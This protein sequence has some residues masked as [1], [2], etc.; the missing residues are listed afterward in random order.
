MDYKSATE[1]VNQS[2]LNSG[3]K[4]D[5]GKNYVKFCRHQSDLK[6]QADLRFQVLSPKPQNRSERSELA[7]FETCREI[8][9]KSNKFVAPAITHLAKLSAIAH[10]NLGNLHKDRN[11]W[12]DAIVQYRKAI[13]IDSKYQSAYLN[14]AQVLNEVEQTLEATLYFECAKKLDEQKAYW[15]LCLDQANNY[16]ANYDYQEAVGYYLQALRMQPTN[17]AIYFKLSQ[18]FYNLQQID[19]ALNY[20]KQA[21]DL[22]DQR[23]NEQRLM[24]SFSEYA[25]KIAQVCEQKKDFAMAI[26]FYLESLDSE[27]CRW[28]AYFNLGNI[29]ARLRQWNTSLKYYQQAMQIKPAN[30]WLL[31]NAGNVCLELGYFF[32]AREYYLEAIKLNK[33]GSAWTHYYLGEVFQ[34]LKIWTKSLAAYKAAQ[35]LNPHLKQINQKIIQVQKLVPSN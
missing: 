16:F 4:S 6:S 26:K 10:N 30:Y 34:N 18:C 25:Y 1:S 29:F 9:V 2:L 5:L 15:Q 28:Q 35:L 23:L 27:E 7:S 12:Q 21:I 22:N 13:A 8:T 14:L 33:I 11:Q 19:Q 3:Q 24:P 17:S 32:S 20:F 31:N